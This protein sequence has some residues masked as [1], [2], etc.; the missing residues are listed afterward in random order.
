MT[1]YHRIDP[2]TLAVVS[3]LAH[4]KSD[5]GA[6]RLTRIFNFISRQV[7]TIYERGVLQEYTIPKH[8]DYGSS[9][10]GYSAAVT[11]SMQIHDFK[12]LP[13]PDE[14]VQMHAKLR[15]R[16]GKPPPLDEVMQGIPQMKKGT[17]K[18]PAAGKTTP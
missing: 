18:A 12:D 11:S 9:S 8:T 7:T 4:D 17:L 5:W 16:G 3:S 10:K 1:D 14:I 13:N 2:T 15:E 6:P